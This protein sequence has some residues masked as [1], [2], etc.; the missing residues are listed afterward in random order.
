[1]CKMDTLI[2]CT[3]FKLSC[4]MGHSIWFCLFF[5]RKCSLVQ[6]LAESFCMLSHH[7]IVPTCVT[8]SY[9]FESKITKLL[10]F[11]PFC[12]KNKNKKPQTKQNSILILFEG[13]TT[14]VG[15]YMFVSKF[16]CRKCSSWDYCLNAQ[17][18]GIKWFSFPSPSL[19]FLKG[20]YIISSQMPSVH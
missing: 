6:W 10:I 17:I 4:P 20:K 13:V 19:F 7:E 16:K 12:N 15:L 11:F 5:K 8:E 1:M 14:L 2:N 18:F 9:F 3:Y